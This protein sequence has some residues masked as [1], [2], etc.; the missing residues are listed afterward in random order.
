MLTAESESEQDE[1]HP[2]DR[3]P[4]QVAKA[5]ELKLN[6]VDFYEPFLE[7][8][9]LIPGKP[10]TEEELVKF[11]EDHDRYGPRAAESRPAASGLRLTPLSVPLPPQ[12]ADPEEAATP[13]HVRNLG[14]RPERGSAAP[15]GPLLGRSNAARLSLLPRRTTSPAS[16][17]S[18]SRRNRT[19]VGQRAPARPSAS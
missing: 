4:L 16:T 14:K 18:L 8:P 9:T 15:A 1:K 5:L 17:S 10:Y 3:F 19:Q 7:H 12:K 6:E 2:D 11:I 13:Q